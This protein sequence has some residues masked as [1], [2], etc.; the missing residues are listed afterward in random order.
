MKPIKEMAKEIAELTQC[1]GIRDY[2]DP[3]SPLNVCVYDSSKIFNFFC[4][5]EEVA[6]A[7]EEGNYGLAEWYIDLHK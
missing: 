5:C 2:F 7:I 6:G 4:I 3:S 1:G